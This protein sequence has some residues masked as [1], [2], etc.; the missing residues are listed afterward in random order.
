M[1]LSWNT[2]FCA[3]GVTAGCAD[4]DGSCVRSLTGVRESDALAVSAGAGK[5]EAAAEAGA[6]GTVDDA[7]EGVVAAGAGEEASRV[8]SPT[9]ADDDDGVVS[10]NG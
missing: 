10:A 9:G 3:G 6:A 4:A 1:E 8:E 7:N 5:E 2:V